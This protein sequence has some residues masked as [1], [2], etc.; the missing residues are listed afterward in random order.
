MPDADVI[1]KF[2]YAFGSNVFVATNKGLYVLDGNSLTLIGSAVSV[3]AICE[4]NG[5]LYVG[6][7]DNGGVS[8]VNIGST[9]G[10]T[11]LSSVSIF[12]KLSIK[13]LASY[14]DGEML[15]ATVASDTINGIFYAT[16]MLQKL[17]PIDA[18]KN[19]TLA[20]ASGG[21]AFVANKNVVN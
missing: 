11:T 18:T 8:R 21:D 20:T 6:Y 15:V 1:P 3:A 10:K 19:S 2:T 7:E 16:P 17:Y 13:G 5:K 9:I 14:N 12:D 4:F